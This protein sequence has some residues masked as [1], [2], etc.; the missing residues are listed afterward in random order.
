MNNK[1]I[2]NSPKIELKSVVAENLLLTL[3]NVKTN[4]IYND[5]KGD[6]FDKNN[7]Y[8]AGDGSDAGAKGGLSDWDNL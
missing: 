4:S 5:I 6:Q 1:K 2:Y 7:N 3:S 8:T